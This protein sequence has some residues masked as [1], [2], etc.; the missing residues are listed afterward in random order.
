MPCTVISRL[1]AA[2]LF[3]FS[4]AASAADSNRPPR[5]LPVPAIGLRVELAGLKLAPLPDD[6]RATCGQLADDERYTSRMWIFGKAKDAASTY[7]ILSGYFKRRRPEPGRRL[8]EVPDTGS[9]FTV[10]GSTCGGDDA[11]ETFDVRD[12]NAE[13]TGNVPIPILRELARDLAVQTVRAFGGPE[14]LRAEIKN[15]RIDFDQLSP[16]LQ[17][18]FRPYF[19]GPSRQR[20]TARS[21]AEAGPE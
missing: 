7:Y 12:P 8:Y 14:R 11:R 13:N 2:G 17:E 19:D 20:G 5:F 1:V 9:V 3:A 15:Q 6:L 10:H 21:K 18:A 16:E 4:A